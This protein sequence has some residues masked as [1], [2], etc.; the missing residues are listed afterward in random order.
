VS[1]I[2]AAVL[3]SLALTG[4]TAASAQDTTAKSEPKAKLPP[5][6]AAERLTV[7]RRSSVWKPTDIPNMDVIKGPFADGFAPEQEITC[8]YAA[9]K[10]GGN[11]PKFGC[12][13]VAKDPL[14]VRY[15]AE[16]P[17]LYSGVAS[18]RLLWMLGFSADGLYPVRVTCRKC[19]KETAVQGVE[20]PEGLRFDFAAIERTF[21]GRKIASV[22]D[23][24]GW[25]WPELDAVDPAAGGAPIEHRD[26]LKLLAVFL[27]H[28][29]SKAEQQ[30]LVCPDAAPG[31]EALLACAAPV[32]LIHDL[33]KTWGKANKFNRGSSGAVNLEQWT[34]APIWKDKARCVG[35]LSKSFTGT[36]DNPVI[37]E[38]GRAF[39]ANL[40]G[41]ITDAQLNDL[42][43]L[44]R[45]DRKPQGSPIDAWVKAFKDKR[46]EIATTTCP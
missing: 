26:A 2:P 17:E 27:Q 24:G 16:N 14:K 33:G 5:V 22:I 34:A 45:F 39:L 31:R 28:T 43:K 38:A 8:D 29:D 6:S 11:T 18:T 13:I 3:L 4:A 20:V 9:V 12:E 7:L 46:Q 19:P 37:S 30:R 35:N 32:M 41:Q 15:G 40:L 23:N 44:A 25:G 42:F 21:P 36:L 1:R 10:Y